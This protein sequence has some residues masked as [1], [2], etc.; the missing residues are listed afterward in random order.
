MTKKKIFIIVILASI[1]F[2]AL[3]GGSII[4]SVANISYQAGEAT[5]SPNIA[6]MG[7]PPEYSGFITISLPF[8]LENRGLYSIKGLEV[9]IRIIAENWEVSSF[10]NGIEVGTGENN[11]GNVPAGGQWVGDIEVNITTY[12]PNF[13]IE[14]CTLVIE[15][16]ISLIY[17]PLIDVP[18]TFVVEVLES[19]TAP[20]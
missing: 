14:D 8:T 5:T 2:L 4:Y 9:D 3:Y 1:I 18:L 6:L 20:F 15:V 7:F 19:Y 16:T 10:L 12:I 17:Q 13:A 11:I